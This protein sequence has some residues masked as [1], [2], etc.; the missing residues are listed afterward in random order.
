MSELYRLVFRGEVAEGQ[1]QAVVQK[2][3]ANVLKLSDEKVAQLFSASSVVLRQSVDAKTAAQFQAAFK[4]AGARLRVQPIGERVVP[5][6]SPVAEPQAPAY[7][8]GL[9]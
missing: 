7:E 9:R 6:A 8:Y 1:H 5:V 4:Q 3:L 2:R